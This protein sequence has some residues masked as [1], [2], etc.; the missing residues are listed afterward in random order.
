MQGRIEIQDA[1]F[2]DTRV[3]PCNGSD[4]YETYRQTDK[5]MSVAWI[6]NGIL[7]LFKD[8]FFWKQ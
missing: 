5:Q 6:V 1:G 4:N 2:A 3:L 7:L 8:I